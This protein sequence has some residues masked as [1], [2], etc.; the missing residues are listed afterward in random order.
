MKP[1]RDNLKRHNE[2]L[3]WSN[4]KPL[5]SVTVFALGDTGTNLRVIY[6]SANNS[7]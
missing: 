7:Y 5:F 1:L 2:S 6:I 3:F 4:G